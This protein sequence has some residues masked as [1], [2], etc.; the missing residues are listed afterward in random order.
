MKKGSTAPAK[1]SKKIP[2]QKLTRTRSLFH[3]W[4]GKVS[5]GWSLPSIGRCRKITFWDPCTRRRISQVLSSASEI[6]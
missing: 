2:Q 3:D 5:R 4:R 6:S 1:A